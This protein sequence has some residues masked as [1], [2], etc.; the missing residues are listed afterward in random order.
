MQ[1]STPICSLILRSDCPI[2]QL[3]STSY[4]SFVYAFQQTKDRYGALDIVIAGFAMPQAG[5]WDPTP[6]VAADSRID[7][8]AAGKKH[9]MEAT[10][11]PMIN[12][13]KLALYHFRRDL[14]SNK[15]DQRFV[16]LIETGTS[17]SFYLC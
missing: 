8:T 2:V 5:L 1:S 3:V 15:A 11:T 13:V 16:A 4:Q 10:L 7:N 6:I 9:C 12:S 17:A 14:R